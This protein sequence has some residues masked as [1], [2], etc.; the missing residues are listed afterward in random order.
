[1]LFSITK[2]QLASCQLN[3]DGTLKV[4]SWQLAKVREQ[5]VSRA[6]DVKPD[7]E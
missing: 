1:M 3:F 6:L 7:C 4:G 5:Q 2:Y